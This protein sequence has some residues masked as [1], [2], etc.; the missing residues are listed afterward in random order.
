MLSLKEFDYLLPKELIAQEPIKPRDHARLLCLDKNNGDIVNSRFDELAQILK[1][2][3][4][5]VINDSKVFPARLL[6]HKKETGGKVEIFL[7]KYKEKSIWECLIGGKVKEGGVVLLGLGLEAKLLKKQGDGTC[8]VLFNFEKEKFWKILER[9]GHMPLPPYIAPNESQH[10]DRI[11]YQTVY[12]DN[13]NTGSVAAPTA[14]LHFTKRLLKKLRDKG[15]L[16]IPVTL[17]VGLGTFAM[18]KEDNIIEHKMHSEY[19]SISKKSA[20]IIAR[21]KK[22][23]QRIIG[24]GTTSCR[25]IESYGQAIKRGD[26]SL[27]EKYNEWT[28]IFIYPGY[29]FE[30][31]DALITNFHL[32]KSTLLMLVSALAGKEII[33]E[34][35]SRA[36]ANKYRFYS[37]G[38]AMFIS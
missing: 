11:R 22:N 19:I 8:L 30:L 13:K 25:V 31:L 10:L 37:Y 36:I 3:D 9:I 38:D 6:G 14:G 32:P 20:N 27:G 34:A 33:K 2:G 24:V 28:E 16:I 23:Q 15:I 29:K 26:V 1:K 7:H 17:H 35:Y 21:A 18:V 5:L 4:V 12:A